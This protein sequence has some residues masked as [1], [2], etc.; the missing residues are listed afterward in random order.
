MN[1]KYLIQCVYKALLLGTWRPPFTFNQ[2]KI[3]WWTTQFL[4]LKNQPLNLQI[5]HTCPG[6]ATSQSILEPHLIWSILQPFESPLIWWVTQLLSLLRSYEPLNLLSSFDSWQVVNWRWI[7]WF[8]APQLP[9]KVKGPQFF[10]LDNQF[11]PN[12]NFEKIHILTY[13]DFSNLSNYK[14]M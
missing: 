10:T 11:S 5:N 8:W 7:I 6:N 1:T 14:K 2:S 9:T 3:L 12:W 13:K 4:T